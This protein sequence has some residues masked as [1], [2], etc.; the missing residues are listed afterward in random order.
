MEFVGRVMLMIE[1]DGDDASEAAK[2]IPE[3]APD[4]QVWGEVSQAVPVAVAALAS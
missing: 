4:V 1:L 3:A 2:R